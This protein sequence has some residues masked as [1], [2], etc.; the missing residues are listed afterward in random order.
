[1]KARNIQDIAEE[2]VKDCQINHGVPETVTEAMSVSFW[3]RD[4]IDDV[5]LD[6]GMN[7]GRGLWE[8]NQEYRHWIAEQVECYLKTHSVSGISLKS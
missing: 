8:V 5:I 2:V 3:N 6:F 4:F 7:N 1:M